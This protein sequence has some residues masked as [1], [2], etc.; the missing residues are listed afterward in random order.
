MNFVL[1]KVR[2]YKK[3]LSQAE[4]II[5]IFDDNQI[6][7]VE[8][9]NDYK[10]DEEEWFK[11]SAFSESSFA[12]DLCSSSHST[13]SLMELP[14][15]EF[16]KIKVLVIKQS[17]SLYFQRI[18][19]SLYISSKKILWTIS[20]T[21]SIVEQPE[22]IEIK[23]VSD[24]VY[25]SSTDILYFKDLAR[26]K[27][28]FPGIGSLQREATQ[29]EVNEFMSINVIEMKNNYS[30]DKVDVP[31]R[32]RITS[33]LEKYTELDEN[34]KEV[35]HDYAVKNSGVEV[36][37][38]KFQLTSNEDLKKLIFALDQRYYTAEI[39]DENRV[40]NSIKVISKTN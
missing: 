2:V 25:Q 24:A 18:L 21:P 34:K 27:P 37:D 39:Y 28:I 9:T 4:E 36:A 7:S 8:F 3:I 26:V 12:I 19:P 15:N 6:S 23:N 33:I 32:K 30:S 11:I 17:N 22:H 10:L 31:N 16:C 35:L 5:P 1:G 40:A 29:A 38:G 13:A 20:G 14:T